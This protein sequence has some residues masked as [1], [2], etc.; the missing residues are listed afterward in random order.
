MDKYKILV[1]DDDPIVHDY[2]NDS[3][4]EHE[5]F[6]VYNINEEEKILDSENFDIIIQ[7]IQMKQTENDE[8][9]DL[10]AGFN[11][12]KEFEDNGY[13]KSNDPVVWYISREKQFNVHHARSTD[14]DLTTFQE[15]GKTKEWWSE[16]SIKVL[17]YMK[18][19]EAQNRVSAKQFYPEVIDL[20]EMENKLNAK[21][22]L[23]KKIIDFINTVKNDDYLEIEQFV[24]G[25]RR[26]YKL[27]FKKLLE[28]YPPFDKHY[29]FKRRLVRFGYLKD[30]LKSSLASLYASLIQA[31]NGAEH[32][33]SEQ[34]SQDEFGFIF[35]DENV[36]QIDDDKFADYYNKDVFKTLCL[37]LFDFIV[38]AGKLLDNT[39]KINEWD[40]IS[41]LDNYDTSEIITVTVSKIFPQMALVKTITGETG[42]IHISQISNNRVNDINDH[43]SVGEKINVK[44][45]RKD[46]QFSLKD[47]DIT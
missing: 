16:F 3:L 19:N 30:L 7:D 25:Y 18:D 6:S 38:S 37:G 17:D 26:V 22:E 2:L 13:I 4:K 27:I 42:S 8:I 40:K 45:I 47:V 31:T 34:E 5:I 29:D 12:I 28:K 44:F 36:G 32:R 14:R 20:L 9:E 46:L 23:Q 43:I 24:N 11:I 15:K 1:A 41:S 35:D 33:V 21:I 10:F 39:S